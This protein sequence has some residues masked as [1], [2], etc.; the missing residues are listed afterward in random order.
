MNEVDLLVHPAHQEP[1]GRVLLEAAASGLPMIATAV[2]GTEEI[3]C[4]AES[5]RLVPPA[6]PMSLATAIVEMHSDAPKRLRYAAAA[7]KRVETAFNAKQAA[8]ELAATWNKV[9]N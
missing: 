6:D 8:R 9:M 1:L 2:G 7:R 5:A 3:L 4:N